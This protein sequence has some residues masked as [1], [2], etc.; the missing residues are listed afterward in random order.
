MSDATSV[1]V[2]LIEFDG[3]RSEHTLTLENVVS[4]EFK[5][6]IKPSDIVLVD[7]HDPEVEPSHVQDL[8]DLEPGEFDIDESV[9]EDARLEAD[10]N[11]QF[12][13]W[14]CWYESNV[15][16]LEFSQRFVRISKGDDVSWLWLL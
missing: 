6:G 9:N 14:D 15:S 3:G 8:F 11:E 7:I 1:T 13:I 10:P 4:R 16:Q 2:T 5:L 12:G